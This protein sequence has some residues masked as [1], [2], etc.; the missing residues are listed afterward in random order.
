VPRGMGHL[1]LIAGPVLCAAGI[2]VL[3]DVIEPGSLP[4]VIASAPELDWELAPAS[5]SP[6]RDSSRLPSS[7][8]IPDPPE[9]AQ[10]RPWRSQAGR[11]SLAPLQVCAG[12]ADKAG[13]RHLHVCHARNQP[14]DCW[15]SVRLAL[16][17]QEES[18]T[19]FSFGRIC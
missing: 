19:A 7:P 16:F 8:A 9:S 3:F 1:G 5:T 6:S 4:Q 15:S 13:I 14:A 10:V 17:Y 11:H 2:A 12:I 18:I